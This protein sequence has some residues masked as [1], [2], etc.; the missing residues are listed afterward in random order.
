MKFSCDKTLLLDG[1]NTVQKAV[2][3]KTPTPIL[4]GILLRAES[5]YLLFAA[6]DLEIGIQTKR[7]IIDQE[8]EGGAVIPAK[9]FSEIV[10]K[11]PDGLI[12]C[13]TRDNKLLIKYRGSQV[14]LTIMNPDEFPLLP[15]TE[16]DIATLPTEILKNGIKRTITAVSIEFARPVFTGLLFSL[17]NGTLDMVGTDTHRLAIFSRQTETQ[18]DFTAIIPSKTALEILRLVPE[19]NINIKGSE[20]LV[21]FEWGETR[22][23]TRTIEGTFP[24]FK[25]VI[26]KGWTSR[27]YLNVSEFKG[28]I[29]RANI[30]AEGESKIIKLSG[31]SG[32]FDVASLG[33]QSGRLNERIDAE[34]EG[35]KIEV[36]ANSKFFLNGL[37]A[38]EGE[39]VYVEFNGSNNPMVLKEEGYTHIILP[40]RTA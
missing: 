11:L 21:S 36:S 18:S 38:L 4:Q 39:N 30:L 10:R 22:I 6:T 16:T 32:E 14:E 13:E 23:I 31:D 15:D 7:T 34:V 28:V 27:V 1:I 5:G 35:E 29:E 40:V 17:A 19:G 25:K 8:E 26:P 24:D 37:S 20:N 3:T 33:S 9:V 12:Q 2:A